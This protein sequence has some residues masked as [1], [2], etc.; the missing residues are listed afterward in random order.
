VHYRAVKFGSRSKSGELIGGCISVGS[1]DRR[2]TAPLALS[3]RDSLVVPLDGRQRG[4]SPY[5]PPAAEEDECP[6]TAF[7]EL[8]SKS[9]NAAQGCAEVQ[10][11]ANGVRPAGT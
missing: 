11:R 10:R 1:P 4:G 8:K 9:G 2:A 6:P 3:P 7:G 5:A